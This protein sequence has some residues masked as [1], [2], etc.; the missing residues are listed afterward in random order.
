[1]NKREYRR[2][3]L[4]QVELVA[5]QAVL[6][7]CKSLNLGPAPLAGAGGINCEPGSSQCFTHG[8]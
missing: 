5:D 3:E 1:M 2:P 4:E 6:G 8:S 7:N